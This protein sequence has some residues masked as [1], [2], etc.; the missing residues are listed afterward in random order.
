[1][2]RKCRNQQDWIQTGYVQ[3]ANCGLRIRICVDA[4]ATMTAWRRHYDSMPTSPRMCLLVGV[5][6]ARLF[7]N[8]WAWLNTLHTCSAKCL[9]SA[10]PVANFHKA[11]IKA[12]HLYI[13]TEEDDRFEAWIV[14]CFVWKAQ[15]LERAWRFKER[16]SNQKSLR[17]WT[18]WCSNSFSP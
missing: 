7:E 5:K 17:P 10:S 18:S 8:K 15:R 11:E 12:R 3:I 2:L 14:S 6:Q 1:M 9:R 4:H 13:A 16:A